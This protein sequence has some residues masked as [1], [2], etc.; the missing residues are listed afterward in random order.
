MSQSAA[1]VTTTLE[2]LAAESGN[3]IA[4]NVESDAADLKQA[5]EFIRSNADAFD[6]AFDVDTP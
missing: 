3:K 5:A 1:W 6:E 4:T 2:A